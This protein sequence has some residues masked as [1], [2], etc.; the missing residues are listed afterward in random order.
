MEGTNDSMDDSV[1]DISPNL[2]DVIDLTK[3]SPRS[4][5][6][7]RSCLRNAEN[8]SSSDNRT[9]NSD[10]HRPIP[11][12]VLGNTQNIQTKNTRKTGRVSRATDSSEVLT[13]DDTIEEDKTCYT[14]QSDIKEPIPLTCPICFEALSSKLKPYTTR[15][16]H[17]FCS[18]CLQ[19]SLQK[20]AKKCPTCKA[21]IALKS[22]TRLYL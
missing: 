11:P 22:C 2:I 12:I 20:T 17:L 8:V 19:T 13:L 4:V 14:V 10:H 18:E 3:E 21:T 7:L 6:P 1:I 16:G 15:C 5:R 9:S